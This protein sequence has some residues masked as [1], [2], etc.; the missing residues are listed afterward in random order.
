MDLP[1]LIMLYGGI[2]DNL[3][4]KQ[5]MMID[6]GCTCGYREYARKYGVIIYMTPQNCK[7]SW[8]IHYQH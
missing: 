4:K 8:E 7:L 1:K 5:Q 6:G 2:G 3:N